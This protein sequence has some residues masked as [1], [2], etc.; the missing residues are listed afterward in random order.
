[1]G[2]V[3]IIGAGAA[4]LAAA[5]Q[6]S[7]A[8]LNVTILEARDRIGGRIHSIPSKTGSLPIELGAEF[9]HGARNEVWTSIKA[10]ALNTQEVPD[11]HWQ[12]RKNG[13]HQADHLWEELEEILSRVDTKAPDRDLCSFLNNTHGLS[14]EAKR[15]VLEYVE[16]FH[17]ADPARVSV[18]SLARAQAASESDD[19][20]RQFRITEGYG[21]LLNWF[22]GELAR[23]GVVMRLGTVVDRV[24]WDLGAVEIEATQNGE[25]ERFKGQ[26]VLVTVPLGVLQEQGAGG[27][28]FSPK[29]PQREA[30]IRSLA[31]GAVVKII[32]QF[33]DRFWPFD[34]FGFIHAP[35]TIFPTWWSDERGLVLTGWVGGPRA[36]QLAKESPQTAEAE[37]VEVM[38]NIFNTDPGK[39]KDLVVAIYHH[40]WTNDVFSRGAYSYTP[41]GATARAAE[42]AAS[43]SQTLFFAGEATDSRGEQGTVHA[44][45]AS[46]RRAAQEMIH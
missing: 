42:L 19:G 17:A 26:Q 46:G 9:V 16:G 24:Q 15:F 8:G 25:P 32:F 6:L 29:L 22:E 43:V 35:R 2:D 30:A 4:G 40:D 21:T 3:L 45:L 34:N 10:A 41:V 20:N 11:R 44:A 23:Q 27:I 1:M 31:M 38:A 5:E 18:H 7:R 37:A 12:P 39:I 28:T 13:L 36:Q 14:A 33:R